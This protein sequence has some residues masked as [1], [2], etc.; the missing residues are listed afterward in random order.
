[1]ANTATVYARI[2]P[3]IKDD[4]DKILNNLGVTPSSL[5][6]MLYIQIKLTN[7]I[8]LLKLKCQ[9]AIFL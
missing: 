4:V 8:F 1:M 6:Q 2:E 9:K 3:R 7:S 5:I